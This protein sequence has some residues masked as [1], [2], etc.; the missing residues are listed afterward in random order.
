MKLFKLATFVFPLLLLGLSKGFCAQAT[1]WL[2]KD[3]NYPGWVSWESDS[4]KIDHLCFLGKS[5]KGLLDDKSLDVLAKND[6]PEG[7]YMISDSIPEEK[8]PKSPFVKNSAL[9]FKPISPQAVKA[10][11]KETFVGFTIHGKD[12]FPLVTMY[13]KDSKMIEFYNKQ[14]FK[15]L[16]SRWRG[17][18]ISN[19]DMDRLYDF[20]TKVS[21]PQSQWKVEIKQV[22]A[23]I[24]EKKCKPSA[25][26]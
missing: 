9:R 5:A 26:K 17:L 11:K 15:N 8:W 12:F 1:I 7:E 18:R 6:I 25:V 10:F 2:A 3:V 14:F 16:T 19:W 23:L 13:V 21:I 4:L 20:W 24:S 22:E